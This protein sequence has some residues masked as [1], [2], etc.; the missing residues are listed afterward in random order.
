[1][2][3]GMLIS[4]LLG[5][6]L[7]NFA[8]AQFLNV[9]Y[10]NYFDDSVIVYGLLFIA[11]FALINFALGRTAFRENR[12]TSAVMSLALSGLAVWGLTK[13][14]FNVG[15]INIGNSNLGDYAPTIF[16]ILLIGL[17]IYSIYK[18]VFANVMIGLG[19]FLIVISFTN[20]VYEKKIILILGIVLLI[21]YM[22]NKAIAVSY[23]IHL[24]KYY[25]FIASS[26]RAKFSDILSP[27]IN[28]PIEKSFLIICL[29]VS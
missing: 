1:M 26:I 13:T 16:T 28:I 14:N 12:G 17:L 5:I 11:F 23:G 27:E 7:M 2:K 18:K 10:G 21:I 25:F 4:L 9:G 20:L 6:F 3:K 15:G 29:S 19:L 22:F 8:S 24:I